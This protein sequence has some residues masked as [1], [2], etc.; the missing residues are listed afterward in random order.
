M[1]SGSVSYSGNALE[2]YSTTVINSIQTALSVSIYTSPLIL[3][4]LYRRDFFTSEGLAYLTKTVCGITMVY[5]CAFYIR[6]IGRVFNPVYRHFID[7]HTKCMQNLSTE[8][9]ALISN[10]DFHF[11]WWPVEANYSQTGQTNFLT[12]TEKKIYMAKSERFIR[13]P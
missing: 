9:R 8:N 6:G 1:S 13:S 4:W 7:I 5:L 3:T 11:R 2:R 12:V 10:Y